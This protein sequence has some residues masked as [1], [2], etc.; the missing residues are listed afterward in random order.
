MI[1]IMMMITGIKRIEGERD[2]KGEMGDESK[3]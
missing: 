2:R 1:I 3:W